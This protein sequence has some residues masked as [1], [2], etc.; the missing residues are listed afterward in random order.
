MDDDVGQ[1]HRQ[2]ADSGNLQEHLAQN[3][4]ARRGD[5]FRDPTCVT[6]IRRGCDSSDSAEE[7]E[8]RR[9]SVNHLDVPAR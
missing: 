2:F 7:G 3:N 1:R 9:S 8:P 5:R 4:V 6:S